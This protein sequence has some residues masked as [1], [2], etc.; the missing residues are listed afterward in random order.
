MPESGDPETGMRATAED[1]GR[2]QNRCLQTRKGL[3]CTKEQFIKV[4]GTG[5]LCHPS[6]WRHPSQLWKGGLCDSDSKQQ[7]AGGGMF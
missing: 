4:S 3:P 1:T 6:V 5:T 7:P 2:P